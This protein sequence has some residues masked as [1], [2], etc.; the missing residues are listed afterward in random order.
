M[1]AC[2]D[3]NPFSIGGFKEAQGRQ[4]LMRHLLVHL[5]VFGALFLAHIVAASL[6]A[7]VV[8]HVVAVTVSVQVVL[9]GP[10]GAATSPGLS[11]KQR[12]RLHRH[13]TVVGCPLALGLAWA[14]GGMAWAA[15]PFVGVMGAWA[16][17][18]A[19]MELQFSR[20]MN[21]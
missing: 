13:F 20:R 16:V 6:N 15:G 12:R 9:F 19:A 17:A 10:L 4:I 21:A 1:T 8:F 14:Y 7:S 2:E 5:G 3:F 11:L 18:H